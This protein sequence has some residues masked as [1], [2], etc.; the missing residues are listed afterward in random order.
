MNTPETTPCGGLFIGADVAKSEVVVCCRGS[1]HTCALPNTCRALRAWLK[2]LPPGSRI[3]LES[4]GSYHETLA[5]LAHRAGMVVYLLNPRDVRYY[6]RSVGERAKT[7]RVDARLLARYIACEHEALHPWQPPSEQYRQ[8]QT[9]L[10]RRAVLVRSLG[11]IRQTTA[12]MK[13]LKAEVRAGIASLDALIQAIDR[14]IEHTLAQHAPS[15]AQARRLRSIPGIGLL[16]SAALLNVFERVPTARADAIVAYSGLDPRPCDSGQKRG[17]R[18]L[19]KRGPAELRRLLYNAAM[20]AAKTRAWKPYYL[21]ERAKGL[22]STAALVALAR[23]LLRV[24]FALFKNQQS[25]SPDMA[26]IA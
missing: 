25:F 7:D 22:P 11:A 1:S 5:R 3:G 6:A 14:Q 23:R 24:A 9:L 16:T 26:K 10:E 4:T 20:S 18:R 8:L 15:Q 2:T 21:R 12:K 19:S 17:K 13:V